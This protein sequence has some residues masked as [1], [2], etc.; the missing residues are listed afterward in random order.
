MGPREVH[1]PAVT[2]TVIH[3][4]H[5][6]SILQANHQIFLSGKQTV[7]YLSEVLSQHGAMLTFFPK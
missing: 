7:N 5:G 4:R 1:H 3:K 2:G 6:V